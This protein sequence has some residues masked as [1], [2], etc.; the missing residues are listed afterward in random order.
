[1]CNPELR[2]GTKYYERVKRA[3]GHSHLTPFSFRINWDPPELSNPIICPSSVA[4][5]FSDKG[6][7]IKLGMTEMKQHQE[8][9]LKMPLLGRDEPTPK[10]EDIVEFYVTPH[11]LIEYIGMLSLECNLVQ[12]D[13]I[14]SYQ[15][16]GRFMEIGSAKVLQ[17]RGF[18]TYET[19]TQLF[20]S[21]K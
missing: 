14:N 2:N 18:F 1:M 3:L 8:Y 10:N 13:F 12:S 6:Y 9:S 16:P 15:C 11:E 5:Y 19:I 17:F 21:L 20:S 7:K 4:K